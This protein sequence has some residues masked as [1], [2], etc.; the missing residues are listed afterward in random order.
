MID[1]GAHPASCALRTLCSERPW[2]NPISGDGDST[3]FTAVQGNT[4]LAP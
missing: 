2:Q 4:H 3:M 1:V